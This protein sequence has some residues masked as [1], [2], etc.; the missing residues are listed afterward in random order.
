MSSNRYLHGHAIRVNG[1]ESPTY[2]SWMSMRNR[3][4]NSKTPDFKYYGERGIGVCERWNSYPHFLEDMGPRPPGMTL[5]RI[6]ND[7]DYCPENCRWASRKTQAENSS[8]TIFLEFKGKRLSIHGW[9]DKIGV[10]VRTLKARRIRG[11]S[12]ERI[13]TEPAGPQGKLGH[14]RKNYEPT[15]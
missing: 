12:V 5:D 8:L 2:K 14:T 1:A 7:G 13:L 3:C 4:L 6:D 11:W 10:G 15:T 9:A